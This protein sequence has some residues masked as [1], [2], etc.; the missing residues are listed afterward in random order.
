MNQPQQPANP[1]G[2]QPNFQTMLQA[3]QQVSQGH[4]KLGVELGNC[5]NMPAVQEG[6]QIMAL[7]QDIVQRLE[8]VDQRLDGV[9]QRLDGVDQRLERLEQGH[10]ALPSDRLNVILTALGSEIVGT[11]HDRKKRLRGVV[12][13]W[14]V[15]A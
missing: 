7:L 12:G 9:D 8:R 13:L 1:L 11:I 5:A 4:Q 3:H 14:S 2:P 6:A 10:Q 15:P